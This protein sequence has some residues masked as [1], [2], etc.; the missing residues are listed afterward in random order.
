MYVC[1]CG[2]APGACILCRELVSQDPPPLSTLQHHHCVVSVCGKANGYS[3]H[4]W[5]T[6]C[7]FMYFDSCL[8]IQP[9]SQALSSKTGVWEW[10]YAKYSYARTEPHVTKKKVRLDVI[11]SHPLHWVHFDQYQVPSA[12][13]TWKWGLLSCATLSKLSNHVECACVRAEVPQVPKILTL[14]G[15]VYER[16]IF[17]GHNMY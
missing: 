5:S 15:P 10:G 17:K 3:L 2:Y 11:Q 9:C 14:S 7:S 12:G 8:Q 13:V 6:D 1:M 4:T 16:G